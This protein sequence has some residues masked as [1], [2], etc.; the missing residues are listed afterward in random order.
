MKKSRGF[1][2]LELLL[3]MAIFAIISLAGFTIFNTTFES[4]KGGREKIDRLNLLQTT[5]LLL[6]RDFTQIARRH[7]RTEGGENTN[8]FIYG[9]NGGFSSD[10]QSISFVRHGWSNP[11]LML[12]RSD[13][14]SVGYR[15]TEQKLERIYYNF[16]D[17]VIGEEPKVRV[18]LDGVTELN[19]EFFYSTKWQKEL[20]SGKMP[21]GIAVTIT[22]ENFGKVR[23][24]FLV[25]GDGSNPNK[26]QG[27]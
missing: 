2:L 25:S 4:E 19:F 13:L 15:L 16:V 1:T 27:E 5:F 18:L 17:P 20:I 24:Q 10:L 22:L 23:R 7:V 8:N 3:S 14:Q 9:Q 26:Q 11:A 6:E 21:L 12:P